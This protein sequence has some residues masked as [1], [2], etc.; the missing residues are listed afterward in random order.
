MPTTDRSKYSSF[1]GGWGVMTNVTNG[2]VCSPLE[3][4]LARLE[5]RCRHF[6]FTSIG[7]GLSY[8]S[9]HVPEA[10]EGDEARMGS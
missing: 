4:D 1:G 9:T 10:F 5:P 8:S 3:P 7:Q 6:L 2:N